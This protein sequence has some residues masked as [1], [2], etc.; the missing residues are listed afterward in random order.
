MSSETANQNQGEKPIWEHAEWVC[1]KCGSDNLEVT[2]VASST[3]VVNA[4]DEE[5]ETVTTRGN[6]VS[7]TCCNCK[8]T[9]RREREWVNRVG[10]ARRVG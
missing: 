4:Y 7:A 3:V 10:K 5:Q 6:F 9:G 2:F 8:H 1:P